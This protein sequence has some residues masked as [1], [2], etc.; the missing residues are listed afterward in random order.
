M[1]ARARTSEGGSRSLNE[2]SHTP[3]RTK[4]V[5]LQ[6]ALFQNCL[7]SCPLIFLYQISHLSSWGGNPN[8][9]QEHKCHRALI[10]NLYTGVP[11]TLCP[12]CHVCLV[13]EKIMFPTLPSSIT[14]SL[15]T[16]WAG[17]H[18]CWSMT[19]EHRFTAPLLPAVWWSLRVYPQDWQEDRLRL[20]P[21]DTAS[22]KGW[23]HRWGATML[24]LAN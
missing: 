23:R 18:L 12:N 5:K 4:N 22:Y 11:P 3:T 13:E 7:Y 16:Y 2:S 24:E 6:K 9:N 10:W 1:P 21:S 14:F 19:K 15:S 8:Q 17:L 20:G